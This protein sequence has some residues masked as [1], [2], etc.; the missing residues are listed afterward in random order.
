MMETFFFHLNTVILIL[1][2][3]A[4]SKITTKVE[5]SLYREEKEILKIYQTLMKI[6]FCIM[7]FITYM[8]N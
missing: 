6:L 7:D 2:L 4:R 8:Q 3:A 5:V 1:T